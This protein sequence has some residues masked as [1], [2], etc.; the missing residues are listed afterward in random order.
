MSIMTAQNLHNNLKRTIKSD[1]EEMYQVE[2]EIIAFITPY[3]DDVD[4]FRIGLHEMI[5]NAIEHGND[6]DEQKLVQVEV[7]I[8][9]HS[10][11]IIIQDEGS[12]FDCQQ[13]LNKELEDLVLADEGRGLL[14]VDKIYDE[15][16][17]NESGNQVYLIK[18]REE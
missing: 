6:F 12:G 11:C 8:C 13:Q 15:V 4:Y 18:F 17:F 10:I 2:D 14:I 16:Q 5:I 9:E 7:S 1:F 3:V